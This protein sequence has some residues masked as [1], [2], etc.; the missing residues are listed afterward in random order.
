MSPGSQG[1]AHLSPVLLGEGFPVSKTQ[2]SLHISS[3]SLLTM[4][5]VSGAPTVSLWGSSCHLLPGSLRS[6]S[7][8]L[9]DFYNKSSLSW[10]P[11]ALPHSWLLHL[12]SRTESTLNGCQWA[13]PGWYV[14][15][16]PFP[17]LPSSFQVPSG[18][19]ASGF[20]PSCTKS[21]TFRHKS[22]CWMRGTIFPEQDNEP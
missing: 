2:S 3:Q 20:C 7:L 13:R 10:K 12:L 4:R 22:D 9:C 16:H 19:P 11:F 1:V 17:L 6:H 18:C 14:P 21:H 5:V 8:G 15:C